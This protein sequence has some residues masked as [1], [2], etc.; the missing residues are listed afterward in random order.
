MAGMFSP[1]MMKMAQEQMAKMSPEQIQAMQR[2]VCAAR[3]RRVGLH[4]LIQAATVAA[5]A[6]SVPAARFPDLT[7]VHWWQVMGMDPAALQAQMA[8][9]QAMMSGMS[10]DQLRSQFDQVLRSPR[11]LLPLTRQPVFAHGRGCGC[12]LYRECWRG[13]VRAARS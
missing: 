12:A 8:Q 5:R 9:A 6:L 3:A 11:R 7:V 10:S 13:A 1:E 4:A 2:Q